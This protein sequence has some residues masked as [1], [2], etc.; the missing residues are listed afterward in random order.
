MSW[1]ITA[2]GYKKTLFKSDFN[3]VKTDNEFEY[4]DDVTVR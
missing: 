2:L 4:K 3:F 1:Y